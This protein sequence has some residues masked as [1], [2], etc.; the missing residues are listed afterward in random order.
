MATAEQI[1]EQDAFTCPICLETLKSPKSLP[2]LHTFCETCICEFILSTEQ[3]TTEQ[4]F[5]SYPCPV[6]RTVVK[7]TN[8]EDETSQWAA[9]L[10][11]NLKF[12]ALMDNSK[13]VKQECHLCKRQNKISEAKRWCR[14]CTEALCEE[15][16]QMHSLMKLFANHKIVQIEEINTSINSDEPDLSMISDLCPVHT[17]KVLEAFCFDHQELCCVFCL[18]LQ[19]RKCENVQVIEDIKHL[20]KDRINALVSEVTDA[21]V[22]VETMIKEKRVNKEKLDTTFTEIE[23]QANTFIVSLKDKLD[24]LLALFIKELNITRDDSEHEFENKLKS[25]QKLSNHFDEFQCTAKTVQEHGTLNQI[26]IHFEKSKTELK[27]VLTEAS[28]TLNTNSIFEAKLVINTKLDQVKNV[29]GL[30]LLELKKAIPIE[31]NAYVNQLLPPN[32][33]VLSKTPPLSSFDNVI[34]K[35]IK[36]IDLD[37]FDLYGGVFLSNEVIVSGGKDDDSVGKLKAINISDERIVGECLVSAKVKRLT[38][39]FESESLFVSC[40]YSKLF[41][42]NFANVFYSAMKIKDDNLRNGG[43]CISEGVLYVIVDNSVKKIKLENIIKDSLE[44]CFNINTGCSCNIYLNGLANDSKNNRLLFT[45]ENS[46]VCTLFDG[47]EMF[48]YKDEHMKD[49]TSL[50]VHSEGIIFVGDSSGKIHLISEDGK[51]RRTVL[52]SCNKLKNVHDLCFDK[53]STRLAVFGRGYIEL[54][55]V[56]AGSG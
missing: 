28:P 29:Y 55:D 18:A 2:C 21:K 1:N 6:C 23:V 50:S 30:G 37:D 52:N 45:S 8:P 36:T 56:C 54:Y 44:K 34:L 16:L 17:S 32:S 5:S 47:R 53:S 33:T 3:R 41:R 10:P 51:Q 4:K 13:S 38:F 7:P 31:M 22:K 24:N 48:M 11:Y 42:L 9:S 26:F 15:C 40:Y 39:D 49:T 25:L 43:I 20:K 46:V 19:H 14:D 12:S 27:S 35:H